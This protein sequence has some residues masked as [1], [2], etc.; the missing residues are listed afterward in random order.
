MAATRDRYMS[1]G[2]VLT[3]WPNTT[4]PTSRLDLARLSASRTTWAPRAVG[5]VL[6]AA[7]KGSNGGAH[8]ADDDDF[9][10]HVDSWEMEGVEFLITDSAR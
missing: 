2:S 3:T 7:A 9:T 10:G 6:Q 8:T 1:R 4:W 5:D